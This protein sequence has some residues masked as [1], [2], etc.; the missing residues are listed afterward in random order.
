MCGQGRLGRLGG[1]LTGLFLQR[2][3]WFVFN[4]CDA[5][6]CKYV[7]DHVI[8][9]T[10]VTYA[11]MIF[12]PKSDLFLNLT[13][14]WLFDNINNNPEVTI[15]HTM[16]QQA[17]FWKSNQ[18]LHITQNLLTWLWSPLCAKLTP[19][20][21]VEH[22]GL[23]LDAAYRAARFGECFHVFWRSF[24]FWQLNDYFQTFGSDK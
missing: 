19:D 10:S 14:P 18:M 22:H 15:C 13:K 6:K 3:E 1:S 16:C 8:W 2:S 23:K 20:R 12:N 24:Q 7:N 17:L 21:Q 9:V 11:H 4:L 5:N